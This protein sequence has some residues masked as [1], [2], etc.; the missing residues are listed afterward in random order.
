ML[1]D[2]WIIL[3]RGKQPSALHWLMFEKV[4]EMIAWLPTT[5]ARVA[6]IRTGQKTPSES[7]N[8]KICVSLMYFMKLNIAQVYICH[9]S[10]DK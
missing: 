4:A 7:A 2:V 1:F 10:Y 9:F 5:V 6:I 8:Q 3:T